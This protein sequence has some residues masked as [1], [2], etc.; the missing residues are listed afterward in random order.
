MAFFNSL[1]RSIDGEVKATVETVVSITAATTTSRA[2]H[3]HRA[4]GHLLLASALAG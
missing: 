1:D 3:R 4:R 2:R